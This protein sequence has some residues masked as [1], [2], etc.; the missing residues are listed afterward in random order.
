MIDFELNTPRKLAF[1]SGPKT[2]LS[3]VMHYSLPVFVAIVVLSLTACGNAG[4]V[5]TKDDSADYRAAVSLPPLKKPSQAPQAT[6]QAET[7]SIIKQVLQ[8]A[9]ATTPAEHDDSVQPLIEVD[10]A[11]ANVIQNSE[12]IQQPEQA[13]A[14]RVISPNEQVARL[15]IDSEFSGAW[16]YLQ[17]NLKQS[18]LTVYSRNE[19]A[20]RVSI[21]CSEVEGAPVIKKRGG[22]SFLTKA[23]TEKLEYCALQAVSAKGL[24]LVTVLNRAGQEVSKEYA[25]QIFQ[26]ILNK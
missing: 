16:A 20:G 22:W 14:A 9:D 1:D 24:T 17:N 11:Q 15:Q 18:D 12:S 4:K 2:L 10:G 5:V 25:I 26:R 23:K 19:L 3:N 13:I 6:A 8:P 7:Q 21:G